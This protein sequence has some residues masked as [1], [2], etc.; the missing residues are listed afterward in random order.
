L[1]RVDEYALQS[2]V[3]STSSSS[4][5]VFLRERRQIAKIAERT[6]TTSKSRPR[7]INIHTK[8]LAGLRTVPCPRKFAAEEFVAKFAVDDNRAVDEGEG[9]ATI[10]TAIENDVE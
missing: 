10:V 6:T 9:V 7:A 5:S 3:T 8:S 4:F 2:S 1:L